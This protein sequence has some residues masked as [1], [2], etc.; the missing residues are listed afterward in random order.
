MINKEL[1][2]KTIS[3]IDFVSELYYLEEYELF[4]K[5]KV[6]IKFD[7]L[8][9][10]LDFEFI[11]TAQYPFKD[12]DNES[13]KFINEDLLNCNHVME[14]GNIC[15]HTSHNTNIEKKLI[16][17][18]NS[19][20]AWILKY[21]I[22]KDHDFNYEHIIVPEYLLDRRYITF[23]FTKVEYSFQKGDFGDV[24]LIKINEAIYKK[25]VNENFLVKSFKINNIEPFCQFNKHY[26]DSE[27]T[28]K[29]LFYFIKEQPVKY[30]RFILKN[31]KD[32]QGLFSQEFLRFLYD[33]KKKNLNIPLFIGYKTVEN[34]IHWQVAI[35]NL[36]KIP[37]KRT[38]LTITVSKKLNYELKNEEITW[39]ITRD[40]SYNYFFGRG[41]FSNKITNSKILI[42][43]IGAI[44]SNVAK[45]LTR[46]GC[47]N[48]DIADFDVK[49]IENV[50]RSEYF[51]QH[52]L[53]DKTLELESIL[54]A[55]SPF[56]NVNVIKD[57][58]FE[59]VMKSFYNDNDAKESLI[60]NINDYDIVFDCSTDN[61]LMYIFNSLK[62]DCEI[63]NLSI[64]NHAK[65][66]VCAFYP[67]IYDF[68]IKQFSNILNN[69]TKNL[70]EPTGCWSPTF[71]A[72]YNDINALIQIALKQINLIFNEQIEKRNFVIKSD[73][74]SANLKIKE[75]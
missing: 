44:G 25:E 43:G 4:L 12:R 19:L 50:C 15:I 60:Q 57:E 28:A 10:G 71:K 53:T 11:I 51:F 13:I 64:T 59:W 63:I 37:V 16:I 31:W 17:D 26:I 65:E 23:L 54:N 67:N 32:F 40:I 7:E 36:I 21:Y 74:T 69:D 27:D 39:A 48:I 75:Y 68:V 49:E 3:S 56:V 30:D 47:K 6:Q 22:N 72:S 20:K 46:G 14:G 8:P 66:L 42:I 29:G 62:L 38:S 5:G 34:Q 24:S 73:S 70:Y 33:L 61:D 35:I 41:A 2:G 9:K 52:G 1:I 18:F 45:T 58:Y 55:I